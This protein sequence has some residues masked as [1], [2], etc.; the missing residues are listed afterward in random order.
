M[1]RVDT[2]RCVLVPLVCKVYGHDI[3]DTVDLKSLEKTNGATVVHHLSSDQVRR[4]FLMWDVL[5][6]LVTMPVSGSFASFLMSLE[7][8][9]RHKKFVM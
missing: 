5:K 9:E 2:F 7:T 3:V 1:K 8:N 4:H 6:L